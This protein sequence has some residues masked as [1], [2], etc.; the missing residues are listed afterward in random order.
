ML[1]SSLIKS[2]YCNLG[3][4]DI[5]DDP[6]PKQLEIGLQFLNSMIGAWSV[7]R[8]TLYGLVDESFVLTP[9]KATY[10]VGIGG[11]LNTAWAYSIQ[12]AYVRDSSGV[13]YPVQVTTPDQHELIALKSVSARPRHIV[14][15]P[16]GYP[17]GNL[18]IYPVPDLA[19]TLFWSA[20]KVIV[21]YASIEDSVGVAPE[22]EEALLYNLSLRL[23]LPCN[24]PVTVELRE[25]ARL[26]KS[27]IP[28]AIERAV[29]DGAFCQSE[30][31][32]ILTDTI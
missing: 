25:L 22:Y 8:M 28:V 27:A 18:T 6:T 10:T 16:K 15:N 5:E 17:T 13:D 20:Q 2:A 12:S 32:N 30:R 7:G 9:A 14:Y 29:F 26:S 19:Y 11:E 23:A 21:S 31:Y 3:V 1:V 24:V 4:V